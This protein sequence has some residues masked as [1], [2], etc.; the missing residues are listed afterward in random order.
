[1]KT[2]PFDGFGIQCQAADVQDIDT[3][4]L[5]APAL[6]KGLVFVPLRQSRRLLAADE[7]RL[8]CKGR[9][10]VEWHESSRFCPRCGAPTV[11]SLPLARRCPNCGRDIFPRVTPAVIVRITRG[12]E[13]L[14]VRSRNFRGDHFGL[15]AGFVEI[16]ESFEEA[17]RREV[18]E[19][20]A[21]SIQNLQYWGSQPWPFPSNV[22]V[23]YTALYAGGELRLQ[24]EELLEGR[25]FGRGELPALPDHM[26]I[27]R[28]LIDEWL[29]E[30]R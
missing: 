8:A 18:A 15:V 9:Q 22:M 23:G 2:I 13:I 24:S 28:R 21:L 4:G 6:D 11:P 26:S 14:L 30:T 10:V 16:G 27:A 5:L 12:D 17:V 25:F 29:R 20:T 19:E 3:V 1:M 7:F